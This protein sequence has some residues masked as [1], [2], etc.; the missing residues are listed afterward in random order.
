[1]R[2]LSE[3]VERLRNLIGPSERG[4]LALRNDVEAAEAHARE[5]SAEAGALRG[6]LAEMRVQVSRARQDQEL[7][8]R[9]ID[10]TPAERL[11]DRA[12]RR[13]ASSVVPRVRRITQRT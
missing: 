2:A 8:L 12:S 11:A 13:W 10:M 1:M 5:A 3:E 7:A 6:Q 4:Y 9:Q